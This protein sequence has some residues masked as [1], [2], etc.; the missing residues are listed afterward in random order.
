MFFC[1]DLINSMETTQ[2]NISI[3]I[4]DEVPILFCAVRE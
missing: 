2:M 3:Q 1:E 4:L